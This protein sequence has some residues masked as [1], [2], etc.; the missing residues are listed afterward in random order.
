MWWEF[1]VANNKVFRSCRNCCE[2]KKSQKVV[3][4]DLNCQENFKRNPQ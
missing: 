1:T 2:S 4:H 3:L